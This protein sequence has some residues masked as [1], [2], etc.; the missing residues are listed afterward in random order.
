MLQLSTK[1]Q[2]ALNDMDE[3]FHPIKHMQDLHKSTALAYIAAA[4]I[5]NAI[6]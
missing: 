4:Y 3:S 5:D 1:S 6:F 2:N